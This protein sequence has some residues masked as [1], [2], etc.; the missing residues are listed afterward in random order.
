[1]QD[2]TQVERTPVDKAQ[3]KPKKNLVTIKAN[4]T[5]RVNGKN[6][7]PGDVIQV[8]EATAEE[9]CKPFRGVLNFAGERQSSDTDYVIYRRA[10]R[11]K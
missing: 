8:D 2:D 3:A 5:I 10:E 7:K 9:F 6:H 4:Q 11:V 1:M